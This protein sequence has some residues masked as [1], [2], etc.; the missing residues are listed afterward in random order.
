[1]LEIKFKAKSLSSFIY[2]FFQFFII[3]VNFQMMILGHHTLE[4]A[5]KIRIFQAGLKSKKTF[6][7]Y[8]YVMIY[9]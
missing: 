6:A 5:L 8:F 2:L 4:T 3:L 7:V 1:M 9:K